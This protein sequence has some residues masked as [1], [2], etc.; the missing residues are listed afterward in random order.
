MILSSNP[1]PL[2]LWKTLSLEVAD[3]GLAQVDNTWNMEKVFKGLFHTGR[4]RNPHPARQGNRFAG[5]ICISD[6]GRPAV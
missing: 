2:Q 5:G 6:S 4:F 3:S 1:R